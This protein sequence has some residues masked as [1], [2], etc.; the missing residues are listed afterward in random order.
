VPSQNRLPSSIRDLRTKN[1][2]FRNRHGPDTVGASIVEVGQ[3]GFEV[4]DN[5]VSFTLIDGECHLE[6]GMHEVKTE[7]L[8]GES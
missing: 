5:F 7:S 1:R 2:R 4:L 6:T 3:L 8:V